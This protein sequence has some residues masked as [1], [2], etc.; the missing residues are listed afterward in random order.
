MKLLNNCLERSDL[1]KKVVMFGEIMLRLTPPNFLR[2][3]QARSFDAIYGGGEANVAMA[4]TQFGVP[5]DYVTNS[6]TP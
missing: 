5:V 3:V 2:F 6:A 4:L 1:E